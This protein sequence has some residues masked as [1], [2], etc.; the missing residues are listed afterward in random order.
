ME[1]RVNRL[2]IGHAHI[3]RLQIVQVRVVQCSSMSSK[4]KIIG[5]LAVDKFH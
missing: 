2:V 5:P 4:F 3:A 1:P